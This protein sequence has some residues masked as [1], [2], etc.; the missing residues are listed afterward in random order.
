MLVKLSRFRKPYACPSTYRRSLRCL[1][2]ASLALGGCA[3]HSVDQ[4]I[5]DLCKIA[6]AHISRWSAP[7]TTF[8]RAHIA[9]LCNVAGSAHLRAWTHAYDSC[10]RAHPRL[11]DLRPPARQD[12]VQP[13]ADVLAA[14]IFINLLGL[15]LPL[16]I[17][18]V[19]D[20]IVPTRD[21]GTLTWMVIGIVALC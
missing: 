7:R 18:Q 4:R 20:R 12:A 17:L 1:A 2:R 16:G 13:A 11:V 19:Y 15:A 6:C 21:R 5:V 10:D 9:G 8:R 3:R 14:S